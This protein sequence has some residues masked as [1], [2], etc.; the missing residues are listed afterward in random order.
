[1][2]EEAMVSTLADAD[3]QAAPKALLRAAQRAR[4]IARQTRTPLVLVRDGVLVE[5]FVTD[6]EPLAS[7]QKAAETT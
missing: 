1:M 2:N 4:D 6:V 3:M 7:Q 5:E